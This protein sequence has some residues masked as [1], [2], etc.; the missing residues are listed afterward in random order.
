MIT[1]TLSFI[2]ESKYA[3]NIFSVFM[4]HLM[5]QFLF[6]FTEWLENFVVI[7][8]NQKWPVTADQLNGPS[9]KT[10]GQYPGIPGN[11]ATVTVEC[12]PSAVVGRYVYIHQ[13]TTRL[14]M[15]LCEVE[16]Y[17]G[18]WLQKYFRS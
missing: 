13:P 7:I 14:M 3:L 8:S 10:C 6:G 17:I 18:E 2:E 12:T 15:S 5:L 16:V 11:G 4:G 9:F 1:H